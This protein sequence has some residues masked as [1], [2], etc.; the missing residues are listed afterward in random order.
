M[1]NEEAIFII[2]NRLNTYYCT[3][4]DIEALDKAI[5]ALKNERPQGKWETVEEPFGWA[6][7]KHSWTLD[8]YSIEELKDD[9]K[10]CP[11][12]GARMVENND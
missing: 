1:T 4:K 3:D 10:F 6:N 5:E 12:C 11:N 9:F 7:C 8:E 2:N